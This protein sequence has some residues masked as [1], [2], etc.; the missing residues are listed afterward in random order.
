MR[1]QSCLKSS[2]NPHLYLPN[3]ACLARLLRRELLQLFLDAPL[4]LLARPAEVANT[5]AIRIL[6]RVQAGHAE[7]GESVQGR[8]DGPLQTRLKGRKQ[9]FVV[10]VDDGEVETLDQVLFLDDHVARNDAVQSDEHHQ[11][12][13]HDVVGQFFQEVDHAE[14]SMAV[15]HVAL[16]DQGLTL[17]DVVTETKDILASLWIRVNSELFL[18]AQHLQA[19]SNGVRKSSRVSQEELVLEG[20]HQE[21][22]FFAYVFYRECRVA[23]SN[24]VVIEEFTDAGVH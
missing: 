19:M 21:Q 7:C 22:S 8:L 17:D 24:Q 2:L 14:R 5:R 4:L 15:G 1:Y 12:R 23:A 10:H 13:V 6:V 9:V 16:A 20:V 18:V 3:H 11:V